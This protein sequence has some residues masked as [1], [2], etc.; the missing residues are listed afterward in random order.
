MELV[1]QSQEVIVSFLDRRIIFFGQKADVAQVFGIFFAK[2]YKSD[3][4]NN[5]NIPQTPPRAFD[6]RVEQEL[7][8]T[9]F[10]ALVESFLFDHGSQR[11]PSEFCSIFERVFERLE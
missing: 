9:V 5:L 6:V 3:P 2:A 7:G 4:A 11:P 1:S 10:A 8:L